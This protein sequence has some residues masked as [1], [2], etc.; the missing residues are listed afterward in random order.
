M[1]LLSL[2]AGSVVEYGASSCGCV[3]LLLR[4]VCV[5]MLTEKTLVVAIE[6]I[7]GNNWLAIV[8]DRLCGK[9]YYKNNSNIQITEYGVR[10]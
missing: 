3:G 10:V 5:C 2:E 4:K 1:D 6:S 7:G 8:G 9:I